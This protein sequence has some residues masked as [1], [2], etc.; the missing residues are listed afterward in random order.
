M[1]ENA[2]ETARFALNYLDNFEKGYGM[3]AGAANQQFGY[4]FATECVNQ[5]TTKI[6]NNPAFTVEQINNEFGKLLKVIKNLNDSEFSFG[7]DLFRNTLKKHVE[8]TVPAVK[9][10]FSQKNIKEQEQMHNFYFYKSEMDYRANGNRYDMAS[11]ILQQEESKKIK[12]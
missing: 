6:N 4:D 8:P 1:N 12:M 7:L 11:K 5:I 2:K 10:F 3:G 9:E